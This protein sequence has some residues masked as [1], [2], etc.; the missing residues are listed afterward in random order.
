MKVL[1]NASSCIPVHGRTTEERPI[2]GTESG[3]I[4]LSE[5]L[6]ARGHEVYIRSA[7][8][9]IPEQLREVNSVRYLLRQEDFNIQDLSAIVLVQDWRPAFFYS[10]TIPLFFWTGDGFEQSSNLGIGDKRIVN[11]LEGL[12]TVS[13]WHA[14]SLGGASNFPSQKIF[15]LGNGVSENFFPSDEHKRSQGKMIFHSAPYRGLANVLSLYPKIKSIVK[16]CSLEVYSDM[17]LY[18][19]GDIYQGPH[20]NIIQQLK[21][22]T[23]G[24]DG[25]SFKPTIPHAELAQVLKTATIFPYPCTVQETFCMSLAEAMAAGVVPIVSSMGA[26]GEVIGDGELVI[27]GVPGSAE[28]QTKFIEKLLLLLNDEDLRSEKSKQVSRRIRDN[29]LW[30]IM[31]L[32]FEDIISGPDILRGLV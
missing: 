3:L 17:E 18:R 28:F 2:G 30:D 31:A 29:Y 14:R 7:F 16:N 6:C 25:L 10:S 8:D 20:Q 12:I 19:R 13:K 21:S 26:L 1:F 11:K 22:Q 23:V 32:R 5:A 4:R 27:D 9:A 15:V 24:I